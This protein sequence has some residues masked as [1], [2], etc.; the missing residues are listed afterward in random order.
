MRAAVYVRVSTEDQAREGFSLADQERRGRE[1]AES[2]GWELVGIFRDEGIS[3]ATLDGRPGL[4]AAL[5]ADVD[6]LIVKAQDRLGRNTIDF[7]TILHSTAARILSLDEG[8]L[9]SDADG[10]FIG[11]IFAARSQWERRRIAHRIK[12]GLAEKA[13]Q[14]YHVGPVP[15]GYTRTDGRIEP[16]A[17]APIVVLLF[18]RYATG[19]VS[20][21]ELA[22]W[23][24]ENG[25][26]KADRLGVRNIL[27]NPT[28]AGR[29]V[30]HARQPDRAEF[31]GLHE[32]IIP[33][34]LFA[35]VQGHLQRRRRGGNTAKPWGR[36][37]YPLTGL[38]RCAA[39]HPLM[40]ARLKRYRYMRCRETALRGRDACAQPMVQADLI[41]SQVARYFEG[42]SL[43]DGE[44][45]AAA[46][47]ALSATFTPAPDP[48]IE[49]RARAWERLHTLGE[50]DD[51]EYA[52]QRARLRSA[53]PA[54]EH[55]VDLTAAAE[56]L[57]DVPR[58]WNE[59]DAAGR[60]AL[61]S[62][63]FASVTVDQRYVVALEPAPA[64]AELFKIDREYRFAGDPYVIWLPGQD[65]IDPNYT[66]PIPAMELAS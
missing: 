2:E 34:E 45:A 57:Q 49:K 42:F 44:V 3:G 15:L 20:L 13:R 47:D 46:V 25:L 55:T 43:P 6:V 62:T 24:R 28:Y 64:Y 26:P 12:D 36:Q 14:G 8:W 33:P 7:L 51:D 48:A 19:S 60:R 56:L 29:I 1:R 59:T 5:D 27:A 58:L 11:T 61:A 52:A 54:E 35:R 65:P 22:T 17:D 63:L 66:P 39:G 18:E 53:Q 9:D 32:P 23:A 31:D 40:G 41:E 37:P 16:N 21:R 30:Y 10:E 50:I 38:A 4:L